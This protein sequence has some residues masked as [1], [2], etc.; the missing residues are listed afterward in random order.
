MAILD[1][2][3]DQLR[4]RTS[5]KWRAYPDDVLP[6]WV[7]E[8]DCVPAEPI[9][10]AIHRLVDAGDTG[11]PSGRPYEEALAAYAQQRWGW[12]FDVET[13]AVTVPDVM[14]GVVAVLQRFTSDGSSVM[15]NPPVYPFFYRAL[16]AAGRAPLDVPLTA[17]GRLDLT[18]IGRAFAEQRPAAYLLCS[19]HNPHGTVHTGDEL[20]QVAKLAAEHD[21]LVIS[22]EIHAPLVSSS[23]THMPFLSIAGA[24][25]SVALLSASKAWNLAG[26]KAAVAVGTPDLAAELLALPITTTHGAGHLALMAHTAALTQG[27]P[28]L[29]ELMG[30]IEANRQLLVELLAEHVPG[31]VYRPGPA[32]YLAWVDCSALGL[33]EPYQAFLDRGRVALN[34]GADFG[35][36]GEQCVRVNLATSPEVLREVVRRMASAL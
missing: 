19:P 5:M 22:D 1:L 7:A 20:A 10:D 8:M 11:Y 35:P 14:Q 3:L 27:Q 13:R 29:D 34:R 23:A 2:T 28:W 21:V 26:L 18:A 17:D 36:G 9:R 33:D 25:R 31:A 32:T 16:E 15:I 6:A 30:E 24:R 12:T 4:T